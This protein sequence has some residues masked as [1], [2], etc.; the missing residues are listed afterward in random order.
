VT[1]CWAW[2][3]SEAFE[4]L[5]GRFARLPLY[6]ADR[7]AAPSEVAGHIWDKFAHYFDAV[8]PFRKEW[9]AVRQSL[10]HRPPLSPQ[11]R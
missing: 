9:A 6:Y 1:C 3:T 8:R 10:G 7:Y 4:L 5:T 2:R 11:T